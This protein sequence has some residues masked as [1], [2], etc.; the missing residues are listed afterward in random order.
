MRKHRCTNFRMSLIAGIAVAVAGLAP[1][2]A[3]ADSKR[4]V[5]ESWRNDDSVIWQD[6]II[7][8]FNASHADIE[9]VFAPSPPAE[10][11]AA[12]N[13]KLEGG[14]AGDL[15]T[16]RPFDASLELY[17]KG[18]LATLNDLKGME[19]FSDVA[20]SAWITD[21]GS[22]VFCVPMASVIHGFIYN[23]EVFEGLGLKQP[24]T[25]AEFYQVLDAIKQAGEVTPM[26][27]GTADQWEAAT[28]GFQNI[29][30]NYWKGE[31]GRRN[32]IAGKQ[33]LTDAHYVAVWEELA[34]WTPYLGR[35]YKAQKYPDT[36][37]LFALG[38]AAIYPAGSWDIS[39]FNTQADFKFGAFPPPL[40]SGQD[41]C[42]ISDHTDIAL[43]LNA[44][45]ENKASARTFLGWV[46]SKEFATL[47]SNALPGFFSLSKHP[48]EVAD[49]VA[50]VFLSWR[51]SCESTIRNSYQILSRGMPNLENELWNVSAQVIN[52]TLSPAQAAEQVQS[53]LAKWYAPQQ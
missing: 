1:L 24:K 34:R 2:A 32:L 4:L 23:K 39:T 46:A 52:G 29:G 33:K 41:T 53:G 17:D 9:V 26:A 49:P 48:V 44:A 16:C 31:E 14:T 19:N 20:K 25:N 37:N 38:R 8:A 42:Y 35:G 50:N 18:R 27:L 45:S 51:E 13:A 6:T 12:L 47:Y 3:Q 36:Q 11:N 28:M 22:N 21:D 43:G 7:P 15:I 5:I 10:Y 30:P 40:P